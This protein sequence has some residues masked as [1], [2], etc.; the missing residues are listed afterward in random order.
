MYLSR[1][2]H[3][4][5]THGSLRAVLEQNTSQDHIIL[6]E[7]PGAYIVR[8]QSSSMV[9]KSCPR[10]FIS[11]H[12]EKDWAIKVEKVRVRTERWKREMQ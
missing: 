3:V 2:L 1:L 8:G 6:L 12:K 10:T 11:L 5:W 4:S 7:T 9:H